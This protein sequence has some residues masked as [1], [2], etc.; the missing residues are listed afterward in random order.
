MSAYTDT[1]HTA[2]PASVLDKL[3]QIRGVTWEWNDDAAALGLSPGTSGAGVIAQEVAAV[4]PGLVPQ[5][6]DGYKRVDYTG[7]IAVLIEAVKELRQEK[8]ALAARVSA[9]EQMTTALI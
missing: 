6:D 8:D 4:F 1:K 9:L 7:L 2:T 3:D 5:G